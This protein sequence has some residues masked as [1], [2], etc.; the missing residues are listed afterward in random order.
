MKNKDVKITFGYSAQEFSPI[1]SSIDATNRIKASFKP[2]FGME[3]GYNF[4]TKHRIAISG[5]FLS[6]EY[7]SPLE[8]HDKESEAT[9]K[10]NGLTLPYKFYAENKIKIK[11]RNVLA[12][13]YYNIYNLDHVKL[14]V[15]LGIG[16]SNKKLCDRSF[17]IPSESITIQLNKSEYSNSMALEASIGTDVLVAQNISMD[18]NLRYFDNGSSPKKGSYTAINHENNKVVTVEDGLASMNTKL[19]GVVASVGLLYKF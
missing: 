18:F 16:V 8:Y 6:S 9:I 7:S 13:Y 4:N 11:S 17:S 15:N 12:Q 3:I 19:R 10:R 5:Q 1:D 2:A 14:Y